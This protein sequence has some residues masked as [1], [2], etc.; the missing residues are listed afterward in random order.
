MISKYR[1]GQLK[2]CSHM[3]IG[4]IVHSQTNNTYSVALKLEEKIKEAGN[5]V[6]IEKVSMVGGDRPENKEKIQL[7]NPPSVDDYDALIFG[8]P[9]HAF[10]LAPAMQV[11]L[12]QLPSLENKKVALF[13]TKGLRF[14]WTGGTRAIGQMKKA[15][16]SNGGEIAGTGI[17]V[18][19]D[20]RDKKIAQL[21]REFSAFF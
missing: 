12:E 10:S 4:I 15:C 5:E 14:E 11:Y 8:S 16:Q 1:Y 17:I 20:Q 19:N 3:K 2:G 13:V 7:E 9:V 18:W 21:V 6:E